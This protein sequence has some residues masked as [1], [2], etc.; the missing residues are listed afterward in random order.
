MNFRTLKVAAAAALALAMPAGV[1]AQP[2][3]LPP[4]KIGLILSFSGGDN[5][6]EGKEED[7]A[8]R[9]FIAKNGDVIAGRKVQ[10]IKKD[11]GGIAPDVAKRLAQELIVQDK[12]DILVGSAYTPN[13]IAI[14][15][16]STQAKVPYFIINAATSNII[17]KAPY[18]A[19]FGFT[20][21]QITVP[22]AR[23]AIQQGYRTAYAVYQDYGPGIDAGQAFEKTFSAEGGKMLGESR[24]PVNNLDFS[25]YI[26]RVKDAKPDIM[27]V[28]INATGGGTQFLKAVK[29]A[30]LEKNGTHVLATGDIV[31]EPIL[32][33]SG[34]AAVGIITTFDYDAWHDSPANREFVRLWQAAYPSK[35]ELPDFASCAAWDAMG[36]VYYV[37]KAQ[38]GK[39]DPDKTMEL[40]KGYQWESPRGRAMIDPATRDIIQNVYLRRTVR[41]PKTGALENREFGTIRMQKDPNEQ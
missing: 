29:E 38:G 26:Q 25:A 15:S 22:A 41:N 11:D 35:V 12:V 24:I 14:A 21:A 20:T 19:R 10:I 31:N 13:A 8:I 5:V 37:A 39:I 33:A 36:A 6:A 7:A 2:S 32:Q 34:D 27:F 28:F 16:V 3:Q 4:L 40:I 23:W 17:A 30:G 9:A 18:T 1:F